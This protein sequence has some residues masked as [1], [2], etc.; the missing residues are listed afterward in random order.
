MEIPEEAKKQMDVGPEHPYQKY[1]TLKADDVYVEAGAFLGRTGKIASD[2]KCSKIILI[3]PSPS[4]NSII[5]EMIRIGKIHGDVC[6][7][8]KKAVWRERRGLGRFVEWTKY[9]AGNRLGA[10]GGAEASDYPDRS[11]QIEIDTIDGI[12]DDLGI[13]KV[14]LLTCDVEGSEIDLIKGASKYLSEKRILNV[15]LCCYHDP[16]FYQIAI[17]ILENYGYKDL[18]YDD[19]IVFGHI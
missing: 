15:A 7:L 2:R 5:E 3:E 8:V 17:S 6:T 1:Y 12:L 4:N 14:D 11:V 19:G 16:G 10:N 13:N 9:N 18:K